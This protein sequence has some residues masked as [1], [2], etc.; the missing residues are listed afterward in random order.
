MR[1]VTFGDVF[2]LMRHFHTD[3]QCCVIGELPGPKETG[4]GANDVKWVLKTV[5]E[6]TGDNCNFNPI[7]ANRR[8]EVTTAWH[9]RRCIADGMQPQTHSVCCGVE[10]GTC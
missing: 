7:N 5:A 9:V 10:H 8:T 2:H 1:P 6:Q 4:K 3:K